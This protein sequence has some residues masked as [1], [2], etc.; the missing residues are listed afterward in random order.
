MRWSGGKARCGLYPGAIYS[1]A[2][3]IYCGTF[4][5][6]SFLRHR[7]TPQQLILP[8]FVFLLINWLDY[9]YQR[10]RRLKRSR[11]HST[12][13]TGFRDFRLSNRNIYHSNSFKAADVKRQTCSTSST[14]LRTY[15]L[16]P[17]VF[18]RYKISRDPEA[19]SLQLMRC[20]RRRL[21][22][23]RGWRTK[24]KRKEIRAQE[25]NA[26]AERND[27]TNIIVI[28]IWQPHKHMV[29]SVLFLA[30]PGLFHLLLQISTPYRDR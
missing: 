4:P 15:Q 10:S 27:V 30:T 25:D 19:R 17:V 18:T 9:G 5:S 20:S 24:N 3:E 13:S 8:L 11:Q 21:S 1:F 28:V 29:I 14:L 6:S 16:T 26:E 2:R 12:A 7:S 23:K 22:S